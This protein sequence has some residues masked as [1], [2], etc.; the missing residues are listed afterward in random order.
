MKRTIVLSFGFLMWGVSL[1]TLAAAEQQDIL[2]LGNS[3]YKNQLAKLEAGQ[4]MDSASG[5]AVDLDAVVAQYLKKTDVFIIGE[6]HDSWA[7]HQFQ[8]DF[9]EALVKKNPNI[10]VGFEFFQREHNELLEVWRSGK[11]NEEELLRKTGWYQRSAL[12]YGYTRLIMDVIRKYR[13]KAIGLNVSR[14]IIHKVSSKG[15]DALANEEKALFPTLQTPNPD[16]EYFIKT[17]FGDFAVQVPLW[18]SNMYNAQKCWDVVLAESMRQI[19]KKKEFRGYQGVIIAGS[20]HVAYGLGIPFRYRLAN[21][22][23]RLTTLV[24]VYVEKKAPSG[25]EENP[26]MAALAGQLKP[27]AIFSRGLGDLVLASEKEEK[28]HFPVWGFSGKMV[29]GGYEISRVEKESLA[30][31]W[32]LKVGDVILA[33]DGTPINSQE[34]LRLILARKGWSDPLQFDLRKKGTI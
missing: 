17:T 31:K 6:Y 1:W 10:V 15:W 16:H 5:K 12:N 29:Q 2:P 19:L 3:P 26:M 7:G 27:A 22:A 24:P 13:I 34:E 8:R 32:G 18:F 28:P 9:V 20:G 14:D 21:R 25:S 23:A 30:E 11:M 33:V 4:I